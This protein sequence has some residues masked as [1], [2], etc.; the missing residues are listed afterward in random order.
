MEKILNILDDIKKLVS[1]MALVIGIITPIVM[2]VW[3]SVYVEGYNELHF[4]GDCEFKQQTGLD[5]VL[6]GG[7]HSVNAFLAKDILSSAKYN[8]F[9]LAALASCIAYSLV[10]V[11]NYGKHSNHVMLIYE[12]CVGCM[13]I[14]IFHTVFKNYSS[15]LLVMGLGLALVGG[16]I[17]F[18][19]FCI[20]FCRCIYVK[21]IV[22]MA[23]VYVVLYFTRQL[24]LLAIP[25]SLAH[26]TDFT[27]CARIMCYILAIRVLFMLCEKF[28]KYALQRFFS[29]NSEY[30]DFESDEPE[31][32]DLTET[33]V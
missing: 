10:Y 26:L 29:E 31:D 5:C 17:G 14:A 18:M 11:L 9:F 13:N 8:G 2:F 24:D 30:T 6:C 7:T 3:Q 25:N 16:T 12:L 1:R 21:A 33:E 23:Y 32:L 4:S 19:L 22:D 20:L 15:D 28:A 27:D